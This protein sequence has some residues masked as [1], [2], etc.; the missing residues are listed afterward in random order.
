[1]AS[2]NFCRA[3]SRNFSKL[4][5]WLFSFSANFSICSSVNGDVVDSGGDGGGD[6]DGGDGVVV[7]M[8]NSVVATVVATGV[9]STML[10]SVV[11]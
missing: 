10:T 8:P 4:S 5:T 9:V 7:I 6:D 2:R 11:L 3:I 1:M